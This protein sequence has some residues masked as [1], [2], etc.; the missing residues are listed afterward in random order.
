MPF[1]LL[2]SFLSPADAQIRYKDDEGVTHFVNSIDEVPPK[3]RAGAVG[4]PVPA[5]KPA[6]SSGTGSGTDWE[7]KAREVDQRAERERA[8]RAAQEAKERRYSV[9]YIVEGST[10][11]ASLTYRNDQGGTQQEK[12]AVPWSAISAQNQ[13]RNGDITVRILIEGRE[14]KRSDSEGA[15]TIASAS[16]TCC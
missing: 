4:G 8:R 5:Q 7:R 6:P 3:Y 14:F 1:V 9:T 12:V 10:S 2:V 13:N 15:Y 16:R 11:A